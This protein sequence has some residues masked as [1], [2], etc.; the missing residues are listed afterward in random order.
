[1]NQNDCEVAVIGAGPYGLATA[2]HLKG[3]KVATR[4]FGEPMSF[5][6]RNMPEGM[7]LRSP[8]AASHIAHPREEL[9]LNAYAAMRGFAPQ[10]QLPIGE[11]IR[12]GHWFQ[13]QAV[14]DLDTRKVTR[15]EQSRNG[16]RLRLTDGDD[17]RAR[18]VVVAMGLA[19]QE[20]KPAPFAGLP[21][22]LVSH[23]CDHVHFD[24]YRGKRVAVVGRGQ[25]ACETAAL[26]S[27]IGCEA[28]LISRGD[29][30][31]LAPEQRDETY[32]N[33]LSWRLRKMTMTRGAVGPFPLNWLVEA[34]ALVHLMPP[35][36]RA[37]FTIRCLRPKASA[38]LRSRFGAVRINANRTIRQARVQGERVELELDNGT[39]TFDHVI[40]GTGYKI[41]IA[42][43]GIL[44][45]TLL[46]GIATVDGSPRLDDG[47]ESNVPGL[48]FVGSTA[49]HSFG[50]LM[51][52][53]WGAGFAAASVTRATLRDRSAVQRR[54]S[55]DI[56]IG[57]L[58]QSETPTRS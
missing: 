11:F 27:E 42:R 41:D 19:H 39:E 3:A 20:F 43:L 33:E 36:L 48:H 6:Q 50:P 34:P 29:L 17:V 8:W 10:E 2:A 22:A 1:M 13:Q 4:V 26:L 16:F 46:Q 53:V 54:L 45:P 28:E 7:K 31:W 40:L 37:E 57:R 44:A 23:T 9:S 49:V 14:P 15:V 38:W 32:R 35:R 30:L 24:A 56:G 21:Q 55:S 58:P 5:W 12:Y 47:L 52:F 18:R 51:R 25:S